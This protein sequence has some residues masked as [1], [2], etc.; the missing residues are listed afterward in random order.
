MTIRSRS[1]PS[2]FLTTPTLRF[3]L[4]LALGV[5]ILLLVVQWVD[6]VRVT[7]GSMNPTLQNG[8]YL[9]RLK[10]FTT[11]HHNDIVVIRPHKE[12]RTRAS[13]FVKRLVA[14]PGDTV[15]IHD[16]KV[17]LNGQMLEE[18][19]VATTSARAESFPELV[20]SKGEVVAFEGFA[21]AE[22]PEYLNDTLAMLEPFPQEVLGRSQIENVTYVGTIKLKESFYFVLGDNRGFAAS[23]DSRVFGAVLE[24]DLLGKVFLGTR[25]SP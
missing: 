3:S 12:L 19:Y 7:G 9:L 11:Y 2:P 4:P 25:Q 8:Q 23:G 16:D 24:E 5:V 14:L 21:L 1:R 22:L 17:I 13:R 15:F 10:R 20:I 18:S 6:V